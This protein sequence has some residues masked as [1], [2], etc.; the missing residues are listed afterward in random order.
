MA[1]YLMDKYDSDKYSNPVYH[2]NVISRENLEEREMRQ[3][4]RYDTVSGSYSFHMMVFHPG[5]VYFFASPRLCICDDCLC[6]EFEKCS[7]FKQYFPSVGKLSKKLLRSTAPIEI[8]EKTVSV[9]PNTVFA[10][11]AESHISNFFLV[12]C[13]EG[14]EDSR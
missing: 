2:V 13:D 11:R 14:G 6:L 4:M 1:S 5:Q 8:V 10:I 3:Y 7:S 9:T 12:M